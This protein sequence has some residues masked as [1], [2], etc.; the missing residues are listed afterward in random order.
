MA[1]EDLLLAFDVTPARV[2][3]LHT[4]ETIREGVAFGLGFS[5]FFSLECPPDSRISYLPLDIDI[6]S[7]RLTGYVVCLKER[8]RTPLLSS[9]MEAA[10]ELRTMSPL[11]LYPTGRHTVQASTSTVKVAEQS[12]EPAP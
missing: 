4:R 3:E 2:M 7:S 10:G 8:R 12:L 6:S 5:L 1:I 9:V 11:P